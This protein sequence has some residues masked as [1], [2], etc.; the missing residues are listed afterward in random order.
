MQASPRPT[1]RRP[2]LPIPF[3]RT[4]RSLASDRS[5]APIL[6]WLLGTVVLAIWSLWFA[7]GDVTVYETS[8]KARLE[9]MQLPHHVAAPLSGRIASASVVIGQD[10]L[11]NQVL[12]ELDA[13]SERLRLKEEETK[14]AGLPPRIASMQTE[15][16]SLEQAK[17]QDSWATQAALEAA[18]ARV[19]E[20]DATVKFA[21][22]NESRL[23]KQSAAGGVAE[24]DALRAQSDA[25]KLSASRDAM[26]AELKRLEQDRQV[27]A[28]E[29]Q[30]RIEDLR[31]SIVSLEGEMATTHAA[32]ARI[33][34][35]IE[36]HVI[37]APVTGRIG[38]AM[39]LY[40]GAY[41]S[42]GQR[43]VSVVPAGDLR[44]V[45]DFIPSSAMG[46]MRPG[47]HATM[48]LDGF[49]WAQYG[50][51]KA[52]VTRVASE[53]RDGVVRVEF[54]P[55]PTGN[56][57]MIMQ[58]G[59]PG[60]IEVAVERAAPAYLVLRAAGLLLSSAMRQSGADHPEL[61]R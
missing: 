33:Q 35:T 12:V 6:A 5:S 52:S 8:R 23:R 50:T 16:I 46:R 61:A 55:A 4:T 9:V 22:N 31:R 28:H 42:E 44:I 2:S 21:R 29:A 27:R 54:T 11:A 36:R 39:A 59:V 60:V 41:V 43:L 45:G 14:L 49:P 40:S 32:I 10:V 17:E 20:I 37:R 51:I 13:S 3:S 47:Q 1:T 26:S 53:V 57:A 25:D 15:L 38:D 58:H 19:K 7:L 18:N 48:R 30:A 56:P 34:E 24:I